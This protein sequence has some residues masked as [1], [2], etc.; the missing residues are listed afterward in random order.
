MIENTGTVGRQ[1]IQGLDL[2]DSNLAI[3]HCV[4]GHYG[5]YL[6]IYIYK[7]YIAHCKGVPD[8]DGQ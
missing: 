1:F 2:C 7:Y 5:L 3:L 4:S 6:Y 8:S